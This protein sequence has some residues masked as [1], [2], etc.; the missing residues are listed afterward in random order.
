MKEK[1]PKTK[2]KP[3]KQKDWIEEL[4]ESN[5]D[6]ELALKFEHDEIPDIVNEEDVELFEE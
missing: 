5:D 2:R 6:E 3:K 1:M 4:E